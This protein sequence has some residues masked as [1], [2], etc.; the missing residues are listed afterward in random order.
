[1]KYKYARYSSLLN[2]ITKKDPLFFGDY[3]LDTYQNCEFGC[4][5]CDSTL[6]EII[7]IK[8]NAVQLLKKELNNVEKGT[9][10]VGSAADPYQKAEKKYEATRNLLKIIEQY[11]FPCHILTKSNLILRDLDILS[12]MDTCRVTISITTLDKSVSDILEK[13]V[14]SAIERLQTV[15]KLSETG[16]KAGIAVI[17]VLPYI[18]EGEFENIVKLVKEHKAHYVLHKHLELKGDQKNIFMK[19]LEEF[20][21]GLVEKYEKLYKEG[22]IPDNNYISKINNTIDKWCKRYNIENRIFKT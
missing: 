11:D 19:T 6:D 1:M 15:K 2:K 20:F 3:T 10:I 4:K 14:P 13:K 8:T 16:I 21:P 7:Y 9:I 17:P 5:Y 22:Y 12:K 18:V